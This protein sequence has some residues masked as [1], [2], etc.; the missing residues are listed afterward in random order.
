M[1]AVRI[2]LAIVYANGQVNL[3]RPTGA[4]HSCSIW[5]PFRSKGTCLQWRPT[6]CQPATGASAGLP[7][8]LSP[9][10]RKGSAQPSLPCSRP[11]LP[12]GHSSFCRP[13]AKTHLTPAALHPPRQ[14]SLPCCLAESGC[15][16]ESCRCAPAAAAAAA[17]AAGLRSWD[18]LHKQ[19]YFLQCASSGTQVHDLVDNGKRVKKCQC[20]QT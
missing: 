14:C 19:K 17:A 18:A 8:R 11:H 5:G 6:S 7:H 20:A 15:C 9:R 12:W 3:T 2:H 1:H 4:S 16:L 13:C 10:Q